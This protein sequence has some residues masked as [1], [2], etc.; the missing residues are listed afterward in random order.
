[1]REPCVMSD[2]TLD[3]KL[4]LQKKKVGF[5]MNLPLVKYLGKY[6]CTGCDIYNC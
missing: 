3:E 2:T 5:T 4:D 1:M 6:W